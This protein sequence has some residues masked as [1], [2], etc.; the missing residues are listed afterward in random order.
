M[1]PLQT[2]LSL[3]PSARPSTHAMSSLGSC[4]SAAGV[5][6]ASAPVIDSSPKPVAES[7]PLL[8]RSIAE[9]R[10]AEATWSTFRFGRAARSHAAAAATIGAEKL[11]PVTAS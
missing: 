2:A 9:A 5:R 1:P 4:G 11:V 10:S 7:Q 3:R 6:S 8:P